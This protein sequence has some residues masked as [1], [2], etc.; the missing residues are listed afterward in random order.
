MK[1]PAVTAL[2]WLGGAAV[3]TIVYVGSYFALMAEGDSFNPSSYKREY[4]SY[5][6]LAQVERVPGPLSIYITPSHWTNRLYYPMDLLMGRQRYSSDR[7]P[8]R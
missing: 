8:L 7:Q 5:C 3:V 2:K 1:T 4:R 6:R